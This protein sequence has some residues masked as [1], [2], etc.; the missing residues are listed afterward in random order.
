MKPSP[1][2]WIRDF[3][4]LRQKRSHRVGLLLEIAL[5]GL[6]IAAIF[7][8][9]ESTGLVVAWIFAVAG[10]MHLA[11]GFGVEL[12]HPELT[13]YYGRRQFTTAWIRLGPPPNYGKWSG[14]LLLVMGGV[15]GSLN[16]RWP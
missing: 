11:Q 16:A 13:H 15:Y 3:L 6:A 5:Y 10:G 1:I 2:Q 14:I 12:F 7:V 8:R 4:E 9:G